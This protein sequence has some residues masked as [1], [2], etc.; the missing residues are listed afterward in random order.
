M[1]TAKL[2]AILGLCETSVCRR[3]C[4]LEYFGEPS[5]SCG[6]C[7]NCITPPQEW[8]GTEAARKLMSCVFRCEQASGFAF[9]AQHIIDILCGKSTPKVKQFGH[10]RL[11]T[12]GIGSELEASQWRSVL[13]QLVMLRLV[14][15]DHERFNTLRLTDASREVLRGERS[16]QLR[17]HVERP[18]PKRGERR[19]VDRGRVKDEAAPVPGNDDVF[20]ALRAWRWE[21]AREHGVPAYTVF[22]D[23][24]LRELSGCLPQ[25][26]EALRG[27]SGIG[28][29]KIER[30]GVALLSVIQRAA[31]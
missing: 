5:R 30:Y 23:S 6:N 24:T 11:S 1:A 28:A 20:E 21:V 13:R 31:R 22:H 29:K 12:F 4:L 9:G 25:S 26:L 8:D 18:A 2:D 10:E 16:L 14:K 3:T 19:P 17:R 15:V 27:I 7:D